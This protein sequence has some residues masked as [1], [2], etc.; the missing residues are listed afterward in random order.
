MNYYRTPQKSSTI[1]FSLNLERFNQC[2]GS[3]MIYSGS[4][5]SSEFSEFRIRIQAKIP[6]PCRSGSNPCYL[7][8]F[9]NCKQNHLKFNHKD[10]YVNYLPFSISYYSPT[11]YKVQ[12]SQRNWHKT[13]FFYL[14]VKEVIFIT[15]YF[16]RQETFGSYQN[17]QVIKIIENI[18]TLKHTVDLDTITEPFSFLS[19]KGKKEH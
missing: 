18:F 4:G 10:E 15:S 12:N 7:S 6:N 5:S 1:K 14:K 8:L 16:P 13:Y 11:V 3:G 2:C 17:Q 19:E 9:G